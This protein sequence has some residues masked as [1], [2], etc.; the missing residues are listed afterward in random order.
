MHIF[1]FFEWK[2]TH[3]DKILMD[4]GGNVKFSH[5]VAVEIAVLIRQREIE[6]LHWVP[7]DCIGFV[8]HNQ[9]AHWSAHP[10]VIQADAA[11]CTTC[12]KYVR[13]CLIV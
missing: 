11:V 10:Q 2:N 12:G 3:R 9:L 4:A 6:R 13:L 1:W 8:L 7:R 5:V